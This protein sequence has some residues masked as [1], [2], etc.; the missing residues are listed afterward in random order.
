MDPTGALWSVFVDNLRTAGRLV[1]VGKMA[2]PVAS[3]HVQ[4][5]YWRQI[6]ILGSSMGSPKDFAALLAH[7]ASRR[8]APRVDTVFPLSDIGSAYARLDAADRVGKVVLDVGA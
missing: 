2:A 1:A 5:V 3:L 4:S 7:V 8:W 6:D